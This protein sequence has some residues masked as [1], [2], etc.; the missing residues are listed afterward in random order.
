VLACLL[1]TYASTSNERSSQ[2]TISIMGKNLCNELIK[3][4]EDKYPDF[5]EK[6]NTSKEIRISFIGHSL[7]GLII[8][9]A[10]QEPRLAFLT[11]KLYLFITL[12]TPHLGNLFHDSSIISTGMWALSKFKNCTSLKVSYSNMLL[13]VIN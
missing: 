8:R 5:L 7:G 12:A 9:S 10:L 3:L 1:Q 6:E 4:F 13:L 2:D 11:N